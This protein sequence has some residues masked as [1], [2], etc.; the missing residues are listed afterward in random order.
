MRNKYATIHVMKRDEMFYYVRHIPND[1][2]NIYSVKRLCFS[3]KT[4]SYS[5]GNSLNCYVV[6]AN[7]ED[8]KIIKDFINYIQYGNFNGYIDLYEYN[9]EPPQL[10]LDE[11]IIDIGIKYTFCHKGFPYGTKGYYEQRLFDR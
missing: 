2:S 11:C 3:L 9:D 6:G 7:D 5:M 1:L 10:E 4:K 8:F